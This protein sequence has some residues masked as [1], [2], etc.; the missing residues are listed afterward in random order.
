VASPFGLLPCPTLLVVVGSTLVVA[1]LGSWRWSGPLLM[2]AALY[3]AIGVF[4]LGVALD[5]GL[6]IGAALLAARMV[7]DRAPWAILRRLV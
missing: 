3:G 4:R 7:E 1:N 2:A 5:W 6:L